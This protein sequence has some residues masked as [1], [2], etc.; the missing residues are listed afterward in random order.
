MISKAFKLKQELIFV[1]LSNVQIYHVINL[2][3]NSC[4]VVCPFFSFSYSAR[5]KIRLYKT[6]IKCS[7][8]GPLGINPSIQLQMHFL[9]EVYMWL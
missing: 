1:S 2:L 6:Q 8:I 5:K 4:F 9:K 3:L 7:N